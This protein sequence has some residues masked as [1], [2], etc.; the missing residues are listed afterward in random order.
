MQW[1]KFKLEIEG[2]KETEEG[3]EKGGR[4]KKEKGSFVPTNFVKTLL[5]SFKVAIIPV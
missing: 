2:E 4:E 1:G 3:R 5:Y